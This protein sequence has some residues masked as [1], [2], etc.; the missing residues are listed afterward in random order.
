M[1]NTKD[2]HNLKKKYLPPLA[3]LLVACYLFHSMLPFRKFKKYKLKEF[4]M[5]VIQVTMAEATKEQK[6]DLITE[7]TATAVK[8]TGIPPQSFIVTINELPKD[9]LGLGGQTV[10]E[11]MQARN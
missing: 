11:I 7:L 4:N 6:K 1:H 5:P 2:N 3:I 10:E 9:S 8:I